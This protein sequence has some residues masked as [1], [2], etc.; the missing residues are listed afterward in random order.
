MKKS[1]IVAV[2]LV[3]GLA[4][5]TLPNLG[6][7][8][9]EVV[10]PEQ[11]KEQ[12]SNFINTYL[13]DPQT[14]ATLGNL[15]EISGVYQME[16]NLATGQQVNAYM[17]KDGKYF[18]TE[19]IN[20]DELIAERAQAESAQ[21]GVEILTEGQGD[22]VKTG[23]L[24]TVNYEGRLE[25]GTVFDSSYE[26]GEP[27]TVPLGQG[28]VIQGWEQGLVG[29]KVGEKRKLT[30]PSALG[31]GQAG[32]G[33]TIPPNATLIFEIELLEIKSN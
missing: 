2:L 18:F 8:K 16:V 21:V 22:E 1:I 28:Q 5:C 23:D 17:T 11:A 31:Y 24:V 4:G 12:A 15:S 14:Q 26:R 3:L 27:I 10:E 25:D 30:I 13:V 32:S 20:I 19:G 33:D 9:M 29:M 6:K 7:D